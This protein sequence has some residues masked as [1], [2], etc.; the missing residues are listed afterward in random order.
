M[1]NQCT[2]FRYTLSGCLTPIYVIVKRSQIA[3]HTCTCI[4]NVY[5]HSTITYHFCVHLIL[6]VL[7]LDFF[8]YVSNNVYTVHVNN[9]TVLTTFKY[10]VA[11]LCMPGNVHVHACIFCFLIFFPSLYIP[12]LQCMH[13]AL[14]LLLSILASSS[15]CNVQIYMHFTL[16]SRCIL[17][18]Y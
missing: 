13:A 9:I 12:R 6:P 2:E 14:C 11:P 18:T 7:T 3:K 15:P 8:V 10:F 1:A 5:M 17:C 4:H 16:S